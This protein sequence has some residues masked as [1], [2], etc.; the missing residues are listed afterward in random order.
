M[1]GSQ[2]GLKF[3]YQGIKVFEMGSVKILVSFRTVSISNKYTRNKYFGYISVHSKTK[4]ILNFLNLIIYKCI[5]VDMCF[6][7]CVSVTV[8]FGHCVSV[9]VCSGPQIT[10]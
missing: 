4:I 10:A 7:H 1:Y 3:E 8:C 5:P 9:A 2:V 6:G